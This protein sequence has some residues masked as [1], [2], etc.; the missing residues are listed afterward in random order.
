V[1]LESFPGGHDIYQPHI[2]EALKW[3]MAESSKSSPARRE[4]DFDKFFKKKP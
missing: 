1:R 2:N 3:F 4:S